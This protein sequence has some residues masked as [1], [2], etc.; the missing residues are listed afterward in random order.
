MAEAGGVA[1]GHHEGS[2]S[3]GDGERRV[4][5]AAGLAAVFVVAFAVRFVQFL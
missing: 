3:A 1:V 2:R 4:S 5:F